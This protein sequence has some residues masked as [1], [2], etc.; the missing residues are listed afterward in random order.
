M[1]LTDE[2]VLASARATSTRLGVDP[3]SDHWLCALPLNHV[4]GLSVALRAMLTETPLTLLERFDIEQFNRALSLGATLTSLVPTTLAR[5]GS[6]RAGR[7]RKILLGGSA[8]PHDLA[9][10][11][12]T[13]YGMTETGSGVVYDGIA[14]SKVE[15]KI[16]HDGEIALRCPMALRC[17]RDGTEALDALGFFHTGD[18]GE[19][20]TLGSLHIFGRSSELIITGGENVWPVALEQLLVSS[21]GVEEIGVIGIKDDEWGERVVGVVVPS[22]GRLPELDSLNERVRAEIGPWAILKELRLVEALPRTA[23]GKLD[24]RALTHFVWATPANP[25]HN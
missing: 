23:I 3:A 24:R 18:I 4:G 16:E 2:A 12:V 20:D 15:I 13:T 14:L 21:P 11:I 1:V 17:Y 22:P 19:L 9:T 6:E 8:M 7:F 25:R 5:L 10:N